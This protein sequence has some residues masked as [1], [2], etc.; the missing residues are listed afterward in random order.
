MT[1]ISHTYTVWMIKIT[2][3]ITAYVYFFFLFCFLNIFLQGIEP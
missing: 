2:A 3:N 1:K